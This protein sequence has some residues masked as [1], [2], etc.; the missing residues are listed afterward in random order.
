MTERRRSSG[1]LFFAAGVLFAAAGVGVAF[2]AGYEVA[3]PFSISQPLGVA[4]TSLTISCSRP[5][6]VQISTSDSPRGHVPPSISATATWQSRVT[7]FR[8][9]QRGVFSGGTIE[10]LECELPENTSVAV[11]ITGAIPGPGKGPLKLTLWELPLI[12]LFAEILVC[13]SAFACFLASVVLGLLGWR[14]IRIGTTGVPS[15]PNE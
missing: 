15:A 9:V 6:R 1:R 5:V 4:P 11:A 3:P 14:G 10:V 8:R 13:G 7:T 12:S 2:I